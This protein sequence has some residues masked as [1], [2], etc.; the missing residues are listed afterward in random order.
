MQLRP[1]FE[2]YDEMEKLISGHLED[3][4][5]NRLPQIQKSTGYSIDLIHTVRDELQILNPKPGA[6]FMETYVAFE[7][8]VYAAQ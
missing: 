4:A 7:R 8:A 6:A 1:E 3:L 2:H 5:A